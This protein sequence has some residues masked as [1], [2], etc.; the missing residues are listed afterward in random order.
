MD[1]ITLAA[2]RYSLRKFDARPVEQEK[3][4][5]ILEAARLAPTAVNLQPQHV[6]VLRSPEALE[7]ADACTV[8]HFH[9]PMMLIVS[10]DPAK[11]WVREWDQKNHGEI[12]AAIVAT[13]MMLEA[14]E[15]GLGTTY[16]GMF[17]E[18]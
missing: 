8:H 11:A 6:L 17:D 10:Y 18:A 16:I 14:A 12:D 15:L 5:L 9:P 2:A 13:H 7:K 3:L 4:D 1:F